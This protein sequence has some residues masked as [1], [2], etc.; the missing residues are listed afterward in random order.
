M[1]A[2]AAVALLGA[3]VL[4]GCGADGNTRMGSTAGGSPELT[5]GPAA[6]PSVDPS[7]SPA[8]TAPASPSAPGP[9]ASTAPK[10]SAAP[11]AGAT[12]AAE[13]LLRVTRSGGFA[14][15]TSSLIVKGDGSFVRL[16]AQAKQAGTGKL[17]ESELGKLRTALREADFAHLPR[18]ATGG[19]TIYDGF[20]Y[21]FV[22]GGYEVAAD[23]GS[24]PPALDEV[25]GAL[26][27]FEDTP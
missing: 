14:G 7:A 1:P 17:S 20:S 23:Q 22:H 4:S 12:S 3:V 6:S 21:A 10:T 13:T 15:R 18:V 24:L 16:D 27:P 19:A 8:P 11:T 2:V 26:P 9:A 25:L 5:A